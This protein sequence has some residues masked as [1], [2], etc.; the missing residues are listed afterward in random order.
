MPMFKCSEKPEAVN[1][2][3]SWVAEG[4]AMNIRM[5]EP[6]STEHGTSGKTYRPGTSRNVDPSQKWSNKRRR[7][8]D[9]F[10]S[11]RSWTSAISKNSG[12]AKHFSQT[13]RRRVVLLERDNVKNDGGHRP[14][15][16]ASANCP[17]I[18]FL[19]AGISCSL[20]F[21]VLQELDT[22]LH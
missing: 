9:L 18:V 8:E 15:H 22:E 6:Q 1:V 5:P 21:L 16:C 10:N 2:S 12:R 13:Y 20:T 11:H 14:V 19:T 4:K 17:G 3:K 7:K